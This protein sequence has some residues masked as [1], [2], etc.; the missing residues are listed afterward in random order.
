MAFLFVPINTAAF[1]FVPKEKMN[2]ATGLINLA[3][4]I[5]GSVGIANVTTMLA[6]RTQLHQ[7]VLVC[8]LTPLDYGVRA[9]LYG[10]SHL[11]H[12]AGSA[13]PQ[14]AAQAQGLLYGELQRQAA[15][16]SFVDTFWVMGVVCLLMIPVMFLAK[17]AKRGE[18]ISS[19]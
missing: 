19:H 3:R 2:N 16:L 5:G 14:A 12:A 10:A 6:R 7:A 1:S 18:G 4:N 13:G 9:M 17:K 11:L 15:M 8:N